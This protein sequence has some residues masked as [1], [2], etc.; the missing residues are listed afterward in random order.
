MVPERDNDVNLQ[1]STVVLP[2]DRRVLNKVKQFVHTG[3]CRLPDM[4]R[5]VQHFVKNDL[6]GHDNVPPQTDSRYWPSERVSKFL[7]A[8]Q[9]NLG[10]LMPLKVK[11]EKRKSNHTTM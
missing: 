3:V 1:M 5:H 6:F 7:T 11:S 2:T 10:H 4:Q 8:Q 9:H